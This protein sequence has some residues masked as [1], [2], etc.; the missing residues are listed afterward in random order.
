MIDTKVL[1]NKGEALVA[2][3]LE[4]RGY[5]ILARNYRTRLGEVDLIASKEEFLLFIEVKTRRVAYFPI[6]QVVTKSK[7]RKI[8]KA[9][10][11]FL[12]ENRVQDK[13]CR[14]DVA[15]VLYEG[16]NDYPR[17]VAPHVDY[18]ENAFMGS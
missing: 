2:R 5:K 17:E 9:A 3:F 15:T 12:L 6:S 7:Q 8:I 10:K 18:I 1:G 13:V 4:Q 16:D 14:F 11:Q